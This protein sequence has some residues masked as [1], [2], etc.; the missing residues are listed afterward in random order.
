M[1]IRDVVAGLVVLAMLFG[2]TGIGYESDDFGTEVGPEEDEPTDGSGG[3]RDSASPPPRFSQSADVAMMARYRVTPREGTEFVHWRSARS[4]VVEVIEENSDETQIEIQCVSE[5]RTDV[6]ITVE[7]TGDGLRSDGALVVDC[8]SVEEMVLRPFGHTSAVSR[9]TRLPYERRIATVVEEFALEYALF[10]GDERLG[11]YAFDPFVNSTGLAHTI[12]P[13]N[14]EEAADPPIRRY[15][16]VR[17]EAAGES[18]EIETV[19]GERMPIDLISTG[20]V[21][22]A[23]I[24]YADGQ[25]VT[26]IP[27]GFESD[28][29]QVEGLYRSEPVLGLEADVFSETPNVCKVDMLGLLTEEA[30]DDA[31]PYFMLYKVGAGTCRIEA[32]ILDAP[33]QTTLSFEISEE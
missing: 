9:T 7:S 26:D 27:V 30:E 3:P 23:V 10:A 19:L 20:D 31:T 15:V 33:A 16:E 12:H 22:D 29:F 13:S 21:E 24:V 25:P 1:R 11:G 2:C 32:E 28:F 8:Q 17:L 6:N 5:G 14:A 18:P 4:S